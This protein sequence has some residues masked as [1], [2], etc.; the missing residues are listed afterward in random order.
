MG[1]RQLEQVS[2]LYQKLFDLLFEDIKEAIAR[3]DT[4]SGLPFCPVIVK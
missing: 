4:G 2:E 3:R 1:P